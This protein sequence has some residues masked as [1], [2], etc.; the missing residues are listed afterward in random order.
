M[1]EQAVLTSLLF[2]IKEANA[3]VT[4]QSPGAICVQA[5]GV[6]PLEAIPNTYRFWIRPE[7]KPETLILEGTQDTKTGKISWS[8]ITT[9][10]PIYGVGGDLLRCTVDI[11]NAL[12]AIRT[13]GYQDPVFFC[14]LFQAIALGITEPWYCYTP[15]NCHWVS[16]DHYIFVNAVTGVVHLFPS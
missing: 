8:A 5:A 2:M 12:K 7:G 15:T 16:S 13:A 3:L 10:G 4:K 6:G 11:Y 9:S 1:E 14:S